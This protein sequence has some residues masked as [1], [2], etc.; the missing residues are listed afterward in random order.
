[1]QREGATST[2]N[3][4]VMGGGAETGV[5]TTPSLINKRN[6]TKFFFFLNNYLKPSRQTVE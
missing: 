1:M 5:G 2:K 4:D 6:K 3:K